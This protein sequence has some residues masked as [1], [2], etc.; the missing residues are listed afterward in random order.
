MENMPKPLHCVDLCIKHGKISVL[1]FISILCL[2]LMARDIPEKQLSWRFSHELAPQTPPE[3]IASYCETDGN[4][5]SACS[6]TSA[7][8][9]DTHDPVVVTPS[10]TATAL[11]L[12]GLDGLG[13]A[14]INNGQAVTINGPLFNGKACIYIRGLPSAP[15]NLFQ[16]SK[17]QSLIV[18]Q[19]RFTRPVP[20]NNLCT[21]QV[22]AQR[23][24]V[25]LPPAWLLNN[26]LLKVWG[27]LWTMHTCINTS[28]RWRMPS[29]HP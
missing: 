8:L 9:F 25:N 10:P 26:V 28:H 6:N 11:K 7:V 29:V 1:N 13:R 21:G 17:R 22:F 12:Q 16:G 18:I 15:A 4:D 20:L 24:L 2:R 23:P 27:R 19:G 14:P 5:A 3:P